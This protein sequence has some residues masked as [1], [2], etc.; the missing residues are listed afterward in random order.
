MGEKIRV[1]GKKNQ[2]L[3]GVKVENGNN[4]DTAEP[5]D[6]DGHKIKCLAWDNGLD[7]LTGFYLEEQEKDGEY[8]RTGVNWHKQTPVGK[9]SHTVNVK[10][11]PFRPW[12]LKIEVDLYRT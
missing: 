5:F 9:S 6:V 4:F 8:H 12:S 3:A 10:S 1:F 11:S 7:G 2:Q